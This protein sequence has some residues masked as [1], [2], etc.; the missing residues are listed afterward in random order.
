MEAAKLCGHGSPKVAA[1]T[2]RFEDDPPSAIVLPSPVG[3]LNDLHNDTI[4]PGSHEPPS[5]L[6]RLLDENCTRVDARPAKDIFD[7]GGKIA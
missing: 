5:V 1:A 4:L 2:F 6:A 7:G 3:E